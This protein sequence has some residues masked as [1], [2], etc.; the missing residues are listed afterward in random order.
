M[1]IQILRYI[2][3]DERSRSGIG[4]YSD[5]IEELVRLE[6]MEVE[7]VPFDLTIRDG[8]RTLLRSYIVAP[9]REIIRG[10]DSVDIVH[11]T[12]EYCSF[13][14]PFV[15]AR[16]VVTFHHVVDKREDVSIKWFLTWK[17]AAWM[18]IR[19][20]DRIIAVSPQTRDEILKRYKVDPDKVEVVMHLP[21]SQFRVM[22]DVQKERVVGCVGSLNIRK[23][24]EATVRVFNDLIHDPLLADY[25][26]LICGKGPKKDDLI[27]Q[28]RSLGIEDRVEFVQ[29]MTENE[30][31]RFYNRCS[32]IINTSLHEGLGLVPIEAQ[33]CGTPV[34]Y[35][36]YAKIPQ[37]FTKAAV[38]CKD[39]VDMARIACEILND[40]D[41]MDGIITNGME[42]TS[43]LGRGFK[44][45]MIEIYDP[46]GK[47]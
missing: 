16:K 34:L 17:V 32:L 2:L 45:R 18:T 44:E 3:E 22:G 43:K 25:R 47:S 13:Y 39:E 11:V 24:I 37:E 15:K 4:F 1:K 36:E 26:L 5:M 12:F 42:F 31:V 19:M 27:S 8:I 20:A 38:P 9:L 30:L 46:V 23:N 29:D 35:L 41:R 10:R 21:S 28:I 7:V 6:G 14:L 40:K 33:M